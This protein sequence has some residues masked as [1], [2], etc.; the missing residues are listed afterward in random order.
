MSTSARLAIAAGTAFLL[1]VGGPAGAAEPPG[2]PLSV[3]PDRLAAAAWCD[4]SVTPGSGR[5]AVLLIH[6]TGS[7]P[8][9]AWGWGYE[10]A[11][12]AAGYGI[13]TVTLPGRAVG[14]LT[15]S[16]QYAVYAARYAYQRSGRP[17]AIL[18][19]SQGGLIAAWIATYWPDVAQH[20]T[21]VLSIAG[22]MRGTGLASTICAGGACS[23]L[24]W[25]L[26][27]GSAVVTALGSAPRPNVAVTSIGSLQDEIVF[28]QPF[29][30]RLP[31]AANIMVQG[32][33]PLHVVEHGLLL[34]DAVGYALVIDA[35]TH[36]GPARAS[37]VPLATCLQ[38]TLP[39]ADLVAAA[40]FLRTV[41][42][43]GVGIT[44]P[45]AFVTSEPPLP[46]YA[47]SSR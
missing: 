14:D 7:T 1:V 32:V 5:Q 38:P 36:D 35:L 34:G 24:T 18:G 25:Q 30:D 4:P 45:R 43:L 33:C 13:C 41:V 20:A 27:I 22:P 29:A 44:D 16:A 17:I 46:A 42:A 8:D 9:E 47:V 28:P 10:R 6:G 26:R 39:G 23:P 40:P 37:R 12:P 21:D 2:P 19:H 15:V 11:L 31:G 3:A